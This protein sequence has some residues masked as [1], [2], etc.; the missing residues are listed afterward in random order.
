MLLRLEKYDL[1]VKYVRGKFL[2]IAD[3]LSRAHLA[4]TLESH[5][6]E[7]ELA[8]H[9]FIQYLPISDVKKDEL[10]TATLSDTVLQTITQLLK[11]GWPPNINN[12][13]QHTRDYQNV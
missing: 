9:Q 5:D 1:S 8:I 6:K 11:T 10:R 3:T 7:I 13:P 12:L 4:D 2:Y